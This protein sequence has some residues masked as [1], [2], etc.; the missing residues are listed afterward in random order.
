[1]GLLKILRKLK[2]REREIRLLV[3]GLDNSGK[4]SIVCKFQ[5]YDN[6]NEISPTLG[7][8]IYT[9]SYMKYKLNIWDVGGQDTIRSYWKNYYEHTDGIIWV[10]DAADKRR[11]QDTYME[12]HKLLQQEKLAGASLLIF[13]NKNDLPG[14]VTSQYIA[15]ILELQKIQKRHY[16]IES[17][18]AVTG[19]GLKDG[20]DWLIKDIANRIYFLE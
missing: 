6:M 1:M 20:I 10:I 7:F 8:Q 4:S 2:R 9:S 14:S 11:L 5:G 19:D 3:L 18:S 15:E 12:L 13:A 17:C 16:H